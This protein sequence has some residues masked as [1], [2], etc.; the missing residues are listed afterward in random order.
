MP[1]IPIIES[2]SE[3][4]LI[5][6]SS[7]VIAS[8]YEEI[9]PPELRDFNYV[10]NKAFTISL[11]LQMEHSLLERLNFD[12]YTISPLIFLIRLF[13]ISNDSNNKA[14]LLSKYL[15]ELSLLDTVFYKYS[16][17]IRASSALFLSRRIY[18]NEPYWPN[19]LRFK[20]NL[21]EGDIKKCARD[22]C[23]ILNKIKSTQFKASFIKYSA[24]NNL[25][26]STMQ[27]I[28][29]YQ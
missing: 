1:S 5:G 16:P 21:T 13:F 2:D 9:Y 29:S 4:A 24:I 8:K 22:M 14:F 17:L 20:T 28:S 23:F 6:I 15:L 12:V 7:S 19:V 18:K 25:E 26:V 10:S 3:L 27:N 11:I